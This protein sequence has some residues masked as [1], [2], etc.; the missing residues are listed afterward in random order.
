MLRYDVVIVGGGPAGSTV[1]ALIKRYSPQLRVLLLERTVF[2]R[3]HVGESLLAASSSVLHEMG[4][5]DQI[6]VYGF[7]EKL[8]ASYVWGRDRK[9][10]GFD[11][12]SL[13]AQLVA[14]GRRLPELYTKGWHVRRAE[15]DQLLLQVAAQHGVDIRLGARVNDVLMDDGT[16]RVTGA[17]FSEDSVTR[18][19][20][21]TWLMDCSGQD[22]LLARK[23]HLR[24]YDDRMNNYAIWGYWKGAKW[25]ARYLGHPNL[26]R[27][28]VAT[29]PRGWIWYIPV[30]RDIMSVGFV[31]HTKVLKERVGT[32]SELYLEELRSCSEIHGL[33][34]RAELVRLSRDQ[35][36]DVCVIKDWSYDSRRV[37]GPGWAMAGDAAGFVDPILSSGVMLAHELGQKAAY[38]LNSTFASSD[39]REISS[40]WDFYQE[41]YDTYLKAY[42]DMAAFWYANNFSMESWWW[43]ARR[44]LNQGDG[45]IDLT[46]PEA[47]MRLASGYAN[48]TESLSLFGS[49][50]LHEAWALVDGLF[51]VS[52]E[53]TSVDKGYAH[54]PIRLRPTAELK[55]GF[56][57]Y[58]GAVRRNKRIINSANNKYVDL[59]PGEDLLVD[60]LDGSHTVNDLN[61]VVKGIRAKD[62]RMPIRTGTELLVQ[63][64]NIEALA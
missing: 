60:L 63:L 5:Y 36:R 16:G 29:T 37:A 24:Q 54:A 35:P 56:Y 11:F 19:V 42:R 23:L 21:S 25:Q 12:S 31:T 18:T 26:A 41:T 49:Y 7:V 59:H 38:T 46:N 34:D 47:F 61:R 2:P 10:W 32:P 62:G 20:E 51:G 30:A 39:D 48:R 58:R 15:Y 64:D 13:I 8:G 55:E 50:P 43:E 57:Y 9:P 3:H 40:Y 6:N 22:G 52:P 44:A 27:I 17:I 45:G 33:L 1:G 14:Q 53:S 4:A 28:F